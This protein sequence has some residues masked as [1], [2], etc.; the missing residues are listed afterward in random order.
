MWTRSTALGTYCS[1]DLSPPNAG[2]E[3]SRRSQTAARNQRAQFA[4]ILINRKKSLCSRV[5]GL[6]KPLGRRSIANDFVDR[7]SHGDTIARLHQ[8]TCFVFDD[9]LRD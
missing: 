2:A 5:P 1:G 4:D 3:C 8:K 7:L 9:H 6:S